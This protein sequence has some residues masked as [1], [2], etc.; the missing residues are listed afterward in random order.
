[1]NVA[2]PFRAVVVDYG[3]MNSENVYQRMQLREIYQNYFERGADGMR[4]HEACVAG[5]MESFIG[6]VL[7]SLAVPPGLLQNPYPLKNCPLMGLVTDFVTMWSESALDQVMVWR[8]VMARRRWYLLFPDTEDEATKDA[9][10]IG[11]CFWERD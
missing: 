5:K 7:G 4:L 8:G 11:L 10:T 6:S 1:M 9:F 3:S 2:R